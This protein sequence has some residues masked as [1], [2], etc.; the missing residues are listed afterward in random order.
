MI[1]K[2]YFQVILLI[3][4]LLS[5]LLLFLSVQFEFKVLQTIVYIV[6][7]FSIGALMITNLLG[8]FLLAIN[9]FQD[10]WKSSYPVVIILTLFCYGLLKASW[11]WEGLVAVGFGSIIGLLLFWFIT[12]KIIHRFIPLILIVVNLIFSE[13]EVDKIIDVEFNFRVFKSFVLSFSAGAMLITLMKINKK[14]I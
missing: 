4:L 1:L 3:V 11:Q 14:F 8:C 10:Y 5:S 2:K 12:N 9:K 7:I 6:F 13:L